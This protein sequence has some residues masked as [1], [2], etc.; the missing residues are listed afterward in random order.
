[1][2]MGRPSPKLTIGVSLLFLLVIGWSLWSL[3][4]HTYRFV[5]VRAT[6][7]FLVTLVILSP[8]HR[9]KQANC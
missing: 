6:S 9:L 7:S 4:I 1:M 3:E 5:K 8:Q 2:V